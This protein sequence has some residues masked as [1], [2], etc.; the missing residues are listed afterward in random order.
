VNETVL[1]SSNSSKAS[2]SKSAGPQG[3]Y[4]DTSDQNGKEDAKQDRSLEDAALIGETLA[5]V[6]LA[7]G[8]AVSSRQ[9]CSKVS[10]H[11]VACADSDHAFVSALKDESSEIRQSGRYCG[12]DVLE[13]SKRC[14]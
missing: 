5:E 7:D 2:K 4:K 11:N 6:I 3:D 8:G 12:P 14:S 10:A 1:E 9:H 13:R